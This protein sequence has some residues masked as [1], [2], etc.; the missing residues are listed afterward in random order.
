MRIKQGD[1]VIVI[2]GKDKG[3]EGKVI[4]TISEKNQVVVEGVNERKRHQRP[5]KQG[6]KGQIIPFSAPVDASNVAVKDPK[7][8]KPTRVGYTQEQGKKV[9]VAKKSGTKV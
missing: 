8:G 1:N 7:S 2:A 6:Q 5:R 4:K 3:K 9:R